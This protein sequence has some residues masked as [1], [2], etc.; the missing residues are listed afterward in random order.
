MHSSS[1]PRHVLLPEADHT[2]VH[3]RPRPDELELFFLGR[4]LGT[5]T[6]RALAGASL[7]KPGL[8]CD[9]RRRHEAGG[10]GHGEC[11]EEGCKEAHGSWR[12][13]QESIE[14]QGMEISSRPANI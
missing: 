3:A 10:A 12:S 14:V 7:G 6:G 8:G 11:Q 5:L 13:G 1:T 2:V 4:E 9:E